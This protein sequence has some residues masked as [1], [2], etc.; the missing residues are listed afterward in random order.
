MSGRHLEGTI[1]PFPEVGCI[2]KALSAIEPSRPSAYIWPTLVTPGRLSKW[3]SEGDEPLLQLLCDQQLVQRQASNR[4]RLH[5]GYT[6]E[7]CEGSAPIHGD[8]CPS[9]LLLEFST[10]RLCGPSHPRDE[11]M[12]IFLECKW[13][14]LVV[15]LHGFQSFMPCGF[16][17]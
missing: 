8:V 5:F 2:L 3:H 10:L 4:S 6:R 15:W 1:G 7:S 13:P 14:C 12:G 17:P 9:R 16:P 11:R